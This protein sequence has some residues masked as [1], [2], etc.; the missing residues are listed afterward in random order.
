MI[1]RG[2]KKILDNM[3]NASSFKLKEPK[4]KVINPTKKVERKAMLI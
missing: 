2:N 4:I 3:F 1:N